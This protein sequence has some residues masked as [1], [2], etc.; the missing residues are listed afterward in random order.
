MPFELHDGDGS[1]PRWQESMFVAWFDLSAG[2]G[3][4][5]RVG[6]AIGA[7]SANVWSA[8]VTSDGRRWRQNHERLDVGSQRRSPDRFGAGNTNF[9]AEPLGIEVDDPAA[10]VD[11]HFHDYYSPVPVWNGSEAEEVASSI[12][13]NHKEASGRVSGSVRLGETTYSVDGLFHRDH[14]WGARDWSTIVSHRWFVGTF[15]PELSFSAVVLQ[16]PDGRY[17]RGGAIV[18]DGAITPATHIDIVVA[19]EADGVSHRGGEVWMD[20]ADGQRFGARGEVIDG[21]LCQQDGWVG[22][23]GL[24]RIVTIEGPQLIGFGDI[25]ISNGIRPRDV[26]AALRAVCVNGA[27][28]R[29]ADAEVKTD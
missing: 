4:A 6:H 2:I 25:E 28:T 16:G 26:T 19:G 5:H 22:V 13:P 24:S 14:S 1:D 18:R 29:S 23:E 15:G 21:V 27:S 11:L 10:G 7:G 20:F 8:L 9:V 17:I 12:A 3:G